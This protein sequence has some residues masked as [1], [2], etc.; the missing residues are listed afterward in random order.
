MASGGAAI[1]FQSQCPIND[2]MTAPRRNV[3]VQGKAKVTRVSAHLPFS[4]HV[5]SGR[6]VWAALSYGH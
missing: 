4:L 2:I 3:M 5:L 1:C 6:T